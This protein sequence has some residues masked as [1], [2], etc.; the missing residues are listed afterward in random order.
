MYNDG[1]SVF[2]YDD[3]YLEELSD[4]NLAEVVRERAMIAGASERDEKISEKRKLLVYE[5]QQDD[6]LRIDLSVGSP[7]DDREM[8]ELESRPPLKG[9]LSIP[10][11]RLCVE[12]ANCLRLHPDYD[13]A[14]HGAVLE[15]PPGDYLVT[16]YHADLERLPQ[17]DRGGDPPPRQFI[18]LTSTAPEDRPAHPRASLPSAPEQG[19]RRRSWTGKYRIEGSEFRGEII[20]SPLPFATNLDGN[21][22]RELGLR[23]GIPLLLAISGARLESIYTSRLSDIHRISWIYGKRISE[24]IQ[25][26]L[27]T[28][29]NLDPEFGSETVVLDTQYA[30]DTEKSPPRPRPGTEVTITAGAEPLFGT[31]DLSLLDRWEIRDGALHGCVVMSSENAL[32]LNGGRRAF[33]ALGAQAKERLT[34][35]YGGTKRLLYYLVPHE[36]WELGPGKG[37][38]EIGRL[39]DRIRHFS[40]H[41]RDGGALKAAESL[42]EDLRKSLYPPDS[43]PFAGFFQRYWEEPSREVF[44][45]HPV[46]IVHPAHVDRPSGEGRVEPRAGS[47][48]SFIIRRS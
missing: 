40:A 7:L 9:Y 23:F 35:E 47:G 3:S 28:Y 13:G 11:G 1:L 38:L 30:P 36:E 26:K 5:L 43:M 12:S 25:K 37:F 22:E 2:L 18:T 21:A 34:L 32:T 48:T 39:R 42:K 14:E 46:H 10:S 19:A 8:K 6:S 31:V 24:K 41:A 29:M 4:P 33:G 15:V 45:A 27:R 20:P 16:I 17:G 44:I